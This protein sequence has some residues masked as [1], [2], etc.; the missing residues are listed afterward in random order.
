MKKIIRYVMAA[1]LAALVVFSGA[2]SS[3]P[4]KTP[5]ST[6]VA[7]V[8]A[9]AD[10]ATKTTLE[11]LSENN[12]SKYTQYANAQLKAAVTQDSLDQIYGP[13]NKQLGKFVS[14]TF[15]SIERQDAYT[16][17]RYNAKYEKGE[18]GARMVFDADELI[19]GQWFDEKYAAA[20]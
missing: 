8:R 13:L 15:V 1:A 18:V 9:Y 7:S 10:P 19:A 4:T 3:S 11:G 5:D 6:E 16:V 2:C 14:I 12:L 20:N 17:V